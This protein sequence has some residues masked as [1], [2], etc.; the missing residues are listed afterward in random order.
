MGVR[1]NARKAHQGKYLSTPIFEFTMKCHLCPTKI[2]I[3]TDPKNAE[4]IIVEGA[5]KREEGYDPKE[6]G[7]IDLATQEVTD[8]L[9]TDA[10]YK[11]EHGILDVEKSYNGATSLTQLHQYNNKFSKDPFTVNQLIRKKFRT[12]KKLTADAKKESE[13]VQ[14]RLGISVDILP[15]NRSDLVE[16]KS[17]DWESQIKSTAT[18]TASRPD[19]TT[20]FSKRV[21][22][23]MLTDP[24]KILLSNLFSKSKGDP[25]AVKSTKVE[26]VRTCATLVDYSSD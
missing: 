3:L 5:R 8:R 26:D 19:T 17:I 4:Y 22:R 7:V 1:Y 12:E 14:K 20:I 15:S 21:K 9:A 23:P 16:A 10:F 24:R 18:E 6:I 11:L 25:F 13:A 2:V